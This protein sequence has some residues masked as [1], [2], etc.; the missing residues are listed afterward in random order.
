MRGGREGGH[1]VACSSASTA[2]SPTAVGLTDEVEVDVLQARAGQGE[3]LELHPPAG[4]P[5]RQGRDIRGGG[6]GAHLD[7]AAGDAALH[8]PRPGGP[9]S[10]ETGR[11]PEGDDG[12]GARGGRERLG[13][14]LRQDA[15]V[16]D[17]DDAVGEVLGLVEV[18]GREQDRGAQRAQALDEL[19]GPASGRG[20]EARGGLVEEEQL[21]VADDAEGE[22]EPPALPAGE[23]PHPGVGLLVQPG[24]GEHLGDGARVRVVAGVQAHQLAR[25]EGV[26]E[27]RLLE[28]DPDSLPEGPAAGLRVEPEHLDRARVRGPVALEHLDRGGLP[29]AV[30]AEQGHDLTLVDREVEAVDGPDLPV[31]LAQAPDLDRGH[32]PDLP[33]GV[34]AAGATAPTSSQ[35]RSGCRGARL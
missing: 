1:R 23:G 16:V 21:G 22:V 15:A 31:D 3:R 35:H 5:G 19:P 24:E 34:A 13:G 9:T 25:G 7:D 6:L 17:D 11:H 4:R 20:V 28:H 8:D 2:R 14:A 12:R 32:H 33:A 26:L 18:V 29:G 27:A 30:G 10:P